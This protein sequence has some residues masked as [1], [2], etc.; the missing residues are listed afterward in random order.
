MRKALCV[1]INYYESCSSLHGCV[2]DAETVAQVLSINDDSS[3]NF[4]TKLLTAEDSSS[5]VTAPLLK[6]AIKELFKGDP[7]IALLYYSG[8]GAVDTEGGFLCT[9]EIESPDEGVSLNDV[10]TIAS[11]SEARTKIIILDSCHSG[12]AGNH[13]AMPNYCLLPNGTIILSACGEKEYAVERGGHGVFTS[14]LVQ[15]LLGG[16]MNILGEVS[17]GSIYSYIDRSLG[18]WDQRPVFKANIKNFVCIRKNRPSITLDEL[19]Q[20]TRFF[21]YAQHQ[22]PLDPTYEEDKDK[23]EN[24]EVNKAHEEDFKLLRKYHSLNL[25][26]PVGET[27]MYW[28]AINSKACCLTPLGQHYW[29]LVR[30]GKL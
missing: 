16:A 29:R 14:L 20:I 24:K 11:K 9:S 3:V 17:P 10:M 21:K 2:Y 28:A 1:G 19:K 26:E 7:D 25:V 15:A 22:F 27:Y 4:E 12:T 5:A 13:E 23:T 6:S 18:A 8:H 30:T